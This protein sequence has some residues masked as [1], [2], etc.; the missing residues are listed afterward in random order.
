MY[1]FLGLLTKQKGT[2]GHEVKYGL[3]KEETELPL[4]EQQKLVFWRAARTELA[5]YL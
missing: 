3:M 1:D 5:R 4:L 2:R